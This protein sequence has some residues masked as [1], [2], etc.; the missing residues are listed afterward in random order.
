[1]EDLRHG[2]DYHTLF[3]TEV[4]LGLLEKIFDPKEREGLLG[5]RLKAFHKFWSNFEAC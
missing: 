3:D 4:Y 1:M 5:F 2:T